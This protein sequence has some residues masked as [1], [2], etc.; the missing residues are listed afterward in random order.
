VGVTS[1]VS[2]FFITGALTAGVGGRLG[3]MVGK[4]TVL[5]GQ[6]VF[7][8]VGALICALSHELL[9][10]IVGRGLM[11]L[12]AAIFPLSASILRD[13]LPLER[14]TTG[15]ATLASSLAPGAVFGLACGGLISDRFGYEW[16]FWISV[17]TGG[18]SLAVVFLAVPPNSVSY[19]GR[20]DLLGVALLALGLGPALVA[21]SQ[22]PT[23]GWTS[24]RTLGLVA[25]G[26]GFLLLFARHELETAEPLVDVRL[27]GQ[28]SILTTNATSFLVGFGLFGTSAIMSQ[29]FQEPTRTGYGAGASATQAGLFLVPGTVLIMLTGPLGGRLSSR[30]GARVTLILGTATSAAAIGLMAT[31]HDHRIELYLWPALMYIGNGLSFGAMPTLILEVVPAAQRGEATAVNQIFRLVGSSIGTQLAA[32][33]ITASALSDGLPSEDGYVAAFAFEAGAG[34][35]AALLAFAIPRS[36]AAAVTEEPMTAASQV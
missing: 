13:E 6:L 22:T 26:L 32:A 9:G 31:A 25:V 34:A 29:F 2:V 15:I 27:L 30:M 7:F 20:L 35:V 24:S 5:L 16:V 28:R 36:R 3:D 8:T 14:A 33:L 17:I 21:V 11:G 1:L 12:A 18:V 4:R 10:L 19:P 23:W